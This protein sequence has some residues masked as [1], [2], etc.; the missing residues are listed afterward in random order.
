M[1]EFNE[2]INLIVK[3]FLI[4][5]IKLFKFKSDLFVYNCFNFFGILTFRWNILFLKIGQQFIIALEFFCQHFVHISFHLLMIRTWCLLYLWYFMKIELI[6]NCTLLLLVISHSLYLLYQIINLLNKLLLLSLLKHQPLLNRIY[7][8]LK[9]I[10]P[11]F[12]FIYNWL[13]T[14]QFIKFCILILNIRL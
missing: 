9:P 10:L 1:S 7:L 6:T 4:H 14:L 5:F 11:L 13:I 12:N 3:C 8:R 2:F